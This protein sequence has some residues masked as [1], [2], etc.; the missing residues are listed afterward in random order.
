MSTI[1]YSRA[2]LLSLQSEGR[3]YF[4]TGKTASAVAKASRTVIAEDATSVSTVADSTLQVGSVLCRDPQGWD[5]GIGVDYTRPATA[6][7]HEQK[8]V[9]LSLG[10]REYPDT[11]STD[12]PGRWFVGVDL[13]G[14]VNVLIK[15][16][17]VTTPTTGVNGSMLGVVDGSFAVNDI[18]YPAAGGA[19]FTDSSGGTASATIAANAARSILVIPLPT[20]SAL[21]NNQLYQAAVPFGFTATGTPRFRTS[22]AITTGGKAFTATLQVNGVSA[23]GGVITQ[24]GAQATGVSLAGTALTAGNTGTAAQTVGFIISNAGSPP[25]EGTGFFEVDL[26][27]NDVANALASLVAADNGSKAIFLKGC[28]VPLDPLLSAT[29]LGTTNAA[30]K[31]CRFG[32]FGT[33]KTLP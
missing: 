4:Y 19:A 17:S 16:S 18:D 7:L 13:S 9:C 2:G 6:I 22:V 20:L 8:V 33:V 14:E 12:G 15:D 25:S 3:P 24:S 32:I 10:N 11:I 21:A 26:I 23:T 31:R 29:N 30:V 27:N 5:K 28:G 1:G